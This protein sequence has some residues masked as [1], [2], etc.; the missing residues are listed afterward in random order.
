MRRH[1]IARPPSYTVAQGAR[2]EDQKKREAAW[3]R[4]W[5][6][7]EPA[8]PEETWR[9]GL[10]DGITP[11]A[12]APP[13]TRTEFF[14]DT[15]DA[16]A[17]TMAAVAAGRKAGGGEALRPNPIFPAMPTIAASGR[18]RIKPLLVSPSS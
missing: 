3:R 15:V 7:E 8:L 2:V 12:S 4:F 11:V 10:P 1:T 17:T 6:G 18:H 5:D 14:V 13:A 16:E 9:G